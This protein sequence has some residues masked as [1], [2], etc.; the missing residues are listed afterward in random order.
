MEENIRNRKLSDEV[1]KQM[2]K[3]LRDEGLKVELSKDETPGVLVSSEILE[4]CSRDPP[5]IGGFRMT[6]KN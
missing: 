6:R 5:L 4:L 3:G 2:M 1:K